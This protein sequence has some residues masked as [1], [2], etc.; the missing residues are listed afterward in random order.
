[1]GSNSSKRG[2]TAAATG[3]AKRGSPK[4]EKQN[5]NS[6]KILKGKKSSRDEND[7]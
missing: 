7:Y 5:A 3:N 4:R 6:R 1:M 2:Q